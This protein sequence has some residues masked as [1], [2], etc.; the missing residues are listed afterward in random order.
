VEILATH[1]LPVDTSYS[2]VQTILLQ[3]VSFSHNILRHRQADGQTDRETD[4]S[5]VPTADYTA[6][7]SMIS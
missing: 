4:D 6:C 5:M 1:L 7:S 2:V 3:H